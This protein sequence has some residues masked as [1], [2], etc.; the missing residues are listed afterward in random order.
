MKKHSFTLIELLVVIAIIAIL[1]SMLLPALSKAREKAHTIRCI[2]NEKQIGTLL[3][4][5]LSD[6]EDFFPHSFIHNAAGTKD[7]LWSDTLMTKYMSAPVD[8]N[9]QILQSFLNN[10]IFRCPAYSARI[11][12]NSTV[13]YGYNY[14]HLGTWRKTSATFFPTKPQNIPCK[15]GRIATPAK[16]LA[17]VDAWHRDNQTGY[18]FA[19]DNYT[20]G[21]EN[22]HPRHN[23]LKD[24]NV[25]WADGH[26][27]TRKGDGVYSNVYERQQLFRHNG[28]PNSWTRSGWASTKE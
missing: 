24:Y 14:W 27:T 11:I 9:G 7:N 15:Q 13:H 3:M 25:L 22:V 5:Y 2:S 17:V 12:S 26:A 8:E 16:M 23:G 1:A 18:Y 28:N 10:S 4:L 19:Q 20:G 6:N 21:K